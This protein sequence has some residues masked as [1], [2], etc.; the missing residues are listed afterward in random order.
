MPPFARR[1]VA[2]DMRAAADRHARA[3]AG[4]NNHRKHRLRARRRA[5]YRFRHRKAVGVVRQPHLTV[6][7]T[8]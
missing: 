4:T 7:T 6:Q 8:A 3:A 1:A 5:V 2:A